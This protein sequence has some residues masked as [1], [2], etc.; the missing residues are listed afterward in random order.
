MTYRDVE[1]DKGIANVFYN[2]GQYI[3]NHYI[4]KMAM[5]FSDSHNKVIS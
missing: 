3:W 1:N 4:M 2:L 5:N